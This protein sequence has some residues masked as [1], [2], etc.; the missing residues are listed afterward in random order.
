M[1]MVCGVCVYDVSVWYAC[2]YMC[3]MC[4][5]RHGYLCTMGSMGRLGVGFVSILDPED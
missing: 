4:G 1:C 3:M 5:M 2:V